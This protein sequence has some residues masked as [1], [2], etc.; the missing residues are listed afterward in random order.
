V[1]MLIA[2][3]AIA[4]PPA[5]PKVPIYRTC[6]QM[7]RTYPHGVGMP[8][9]LDRRPGGKRFRGRWAVSLPIYSANARLDRDHD[10]VSCER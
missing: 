8:R 5:L 2:A 10:G 6:A 9:S 1:I 7:H 4:L 3:A